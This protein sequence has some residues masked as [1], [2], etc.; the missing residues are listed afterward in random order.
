MNKR[1]S[2]STTTIQL[3]LTTADYQRI[4]Q[5]PASEFFLNKTTRIYAWGLQ[6]ERYTVLSNNSDSRPSNF[7][8]QIARGSGATLS[9]CT[10]FSKK[11]HTTQNASLRQTASGPQD[12]KNPNTAK[13]EPLFNKEV[14][15]PFDEELGRLQEETLK[16]LVPNSKRLRGYIHMGVLFFKKVHTTQRSHEALHGFNHE[17]TRTTLVPAQQDLKKIRQGF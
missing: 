12:K 5:N 4:C 6:K 2:N 10:F 16:L 7:L 9:E 13:S 14:R 1:H 11:A 8:F 17:S 15:E 3:H